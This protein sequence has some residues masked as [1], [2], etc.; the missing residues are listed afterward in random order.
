[1]IFC[2]VD[3]ILARLEAAKSQIIELEK[4]KLDLSHEERRLSDKLE[5]DELKYKTMVLVYYF[6]IFNGR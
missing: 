6:L 3:D 1:M 5:E 2:K 4:K